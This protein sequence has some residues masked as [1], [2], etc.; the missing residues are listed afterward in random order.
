VAHQRRAKWGD[1]SHKGAQCATSGT[2]VR[3]LQG[4]PAM[5]W[6]GRSTARLVNERLALSIAACDSSASSRGGKTTGNGGKRSS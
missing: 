4:W 2:H 3:A 1:D 5:A 6:G